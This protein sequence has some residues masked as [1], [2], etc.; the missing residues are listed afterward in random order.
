[1]VA[2]RPEHRGGIVRGRIVVRDRA[3]DG[4]AMADLGSPIPPASSAS[5]GMAR[6]SA[7]ATSAWGVAAPMTGVRLR[8]GCPAARRCRRDRRACPASPAAASSSGSVSA[9][10]EG[11]GARRESLGGVGDGCGSRVVEVV[12]GR[13]LTRP[14]L[15]AA[16]DGAP[17]FL[18]RRRH[19]DVIDAVLASAS[20]TA[21]MTPAASRWRRLRRSPSRPADCAC[22]ACRSHLEVGRSS[23]RGIA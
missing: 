16:I 11:R 20:T 15:H 3:A 13:L 10:R 2:P 8:G 5:A 7:R 21:L 18:R 9:R 23:A 22:R 14:L 17:D 19:V 1:M 12:H 6:T 4:A